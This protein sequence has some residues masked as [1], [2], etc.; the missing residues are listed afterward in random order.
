MMEEVKFSFVALPGW[1]FL[2]WAFASE[3]G[4]DGLE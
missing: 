2:Y 4:T 3:S 1:G